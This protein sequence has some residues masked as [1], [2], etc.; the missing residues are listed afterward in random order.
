MTIAEDLVVKIQVEVD[1]KSYEAFKK[2]L[3]ETAHNPLFFSP[4][5]KES[6]ISNSTREPPTNYSETATSNIDPTKKFTVSGDKATELLEKLLEVEKKEKESLESLADD[7]EK[8]SVKNSSQGGGGDGFLSAVSSKNWIA[9]A[10]MAFGGL[11]KAADK[12]SQELVEKTNR[13]LGI[14]S[15]SFEMGLTPDEIAKIGFAAKNVG[16]SLEQVVKSASSFAEEIQNGL[17]VEKAGIFSAAGINPVQLIRSAQSPEDI[18][19]VQSKIW[20]DVFKSIKE[21]GV[22]SIVAS[23]KASYLTNIPS[24]QGLAYQ[25]LFSDKNKGLVADISKTRGEIGTT[26]KLLSNFQEVTASQQKLNAAMD[27]LLS[28]KDVAK[29]ITME[30]ANI[31]T[32]SVTLIAD[33]LDIEKLVKGAQMRAE[34]MKGSHSSILGDWG[35]RSFNS[36]V[37]K[38][39]Q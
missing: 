38:A 15:T 1:D 8:A 16:L 28:V 24:G 14:A 36:S 34:G 23:Q 19:K 4:T 21:S 17:P 26:D 11:K 9:I 37:V 35:P 20:S 2:N 5:A 10:K 3:K 6:G 29:T 18:I 7:A 31:K 13:E 25:N 32:T 27:R 22:S 33:T 30:Y 39:T 12:I